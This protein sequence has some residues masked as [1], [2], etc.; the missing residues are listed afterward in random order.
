MAHLK[1]RN[2]SFKTA[3]GIEKDLENAKAEGLA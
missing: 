1:N 2:P 3:K